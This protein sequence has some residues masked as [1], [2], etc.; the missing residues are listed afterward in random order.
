[1]DQCA[2]ADAAARAG[3]LAA[4]KDEL[5]RRGGTLNLLDVLKDAGF[6]TEFRTEFTS[7]ASREVIDRDS[8]RR[9]IARLASTTFAAR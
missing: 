3:N 1:V 8:L 2:E 9:A 5:I 6:L 4:V 7:V